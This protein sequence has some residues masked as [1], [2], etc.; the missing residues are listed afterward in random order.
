MMYFG[1]LEFQDKMFRSIKK[2]N[3]TFQGIDEKLN[4]IEKKIY[5][6]ITI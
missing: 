4:I 6:L 3:Y 1:F 2:L 5:V